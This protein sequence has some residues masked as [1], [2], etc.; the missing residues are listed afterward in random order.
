MMQ[1]AGVKDEHVLDEK[2]ISSI[3]SLEDVADSHME[4]IGARIDDVFYAYAS[5]GIARCGSG[6][7]HAR[8]Q[9]MC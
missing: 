4:T 1:N 9:C 3:L 7:S 6:K 2:S 5:E 8:S